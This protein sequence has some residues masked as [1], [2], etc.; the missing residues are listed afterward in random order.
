MAIRFHCRRCHQLLAIGTRKA[1][2]EIHCPKCGEPQVVPTQEVPVETPSL[3]TP[4]ATAIESMVVSDW[5]QPSSELSAPPI[6]APS[7]PRPASSFAPASAFPAAREFP[8]EPS[9]I[10]EPPASADDV[11][12]AMPP[13][14]FE[15]FEPP[16]MSAPTFA[17]PEPHA[18]PPGMVLLRR[19]TMHLQAMCFLLLA[20]GMFAAGYYVG[21][22]QP[23][24]S[25]TGGSAPSGSD[26]PPT[27]IEGQVIFENPEGR[28]VGDVGATVIALPEGKLPKTPL[29]LSV[30]QAQAPQLRELGG[31]QV[32]VAA[33]GQFSLLLRPGSYRI[34]FIS[35]HARRAAGQDVDEADLGEIRRYLAAPEALIGPFKYAWGVHPIGPGLSPPNKDFGRSA[36]Q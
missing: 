10:V 17:L 19:R 14:V 13:V 6:I 21:T 32:R 18:I 31:A 22:R 36:A 23:G 7:P 28:L 26:V 8:N 33:K 1:G 12:V 15:P 30:Q 35:A 25:A 11:L 24:S 27:M 34:L 29:T 9:A 3:S 4:D 16:A 2:T 5:L 20:C